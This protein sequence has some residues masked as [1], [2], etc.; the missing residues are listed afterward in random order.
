[1]KEDTNMFKFMMVEFW[2]ELKTAL[3]I[4]ALALS[5]AW[6]LMTFMERI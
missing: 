1:M 5:A 2:K 3:I 4:Y 6:A